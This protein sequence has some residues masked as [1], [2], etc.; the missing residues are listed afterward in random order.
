MVKKNDAYYGESNG[1][2]YILRDDA[3]AVF[4]KRW[5]ELSTADLV[6]EVLRDNDF[7]EADLAELPGFAD[8]VLDKL[9]LLLNGEVMKALAG[10]QQA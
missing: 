8:A 10:N 2:L 5:A 4:Y 3:A 7:W 9:N 1:D 6:R